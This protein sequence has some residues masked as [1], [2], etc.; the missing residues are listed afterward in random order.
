MTTD[1]LQVRVNGR[2]VMVPA[3]TVVAAAI[4]RAGV[5]WSRHSVVGQPRGA[6]C[7]MGVCMECRVMIDGQ[8][9]MR[10]C[11]ILCAEGMEVVT[12]E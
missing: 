7:G 10:S 9:Q 5:A 12:D 3:G 1:Q 11:L 2:L 4:A 8:P 6:L